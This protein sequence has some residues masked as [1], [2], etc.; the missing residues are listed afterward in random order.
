MTVRSH[1][2]VLGVEA[3]ADA[4]TIRRAW[5]ALAKQLHPDHN[6]EADAAGR[7]ALAAAAYA[8]VGDAEAREAYDE[9]RRRPP[10]PV[11]LDLRGS[12]DLPF[13]VAVRGGRLD[14]NLRFGV[15]GVR[16]VV[17]DIPPGADA[18]LRW[19]FAGRG[20]G[21]PAGALVVEVRSVLDDPRWSVEGLDLHTHKEVAL[22]DVYEGAEI[23]VEAP[24]GPLAVSL[25]RGELQS[26]RI[27]GAGLRRG[28]T[29][30]DLVVAL[31][32]RMPPLDARLRA[33]LRRLA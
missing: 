20:A 19:R 4:A 2:E 27:S 33:E 1:Y 5:R 15:H 29:V 18:G 24:V 17:L 3:D 26:L 7:F 14:V 13:A 12:I 25:P 11:A 8:V 9:Q 30:G 6:K 21:V 23:I 16:Q 31:K 10:V 28:F 22:A 32:V